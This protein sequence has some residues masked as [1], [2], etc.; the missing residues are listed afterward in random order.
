MDFEEYRKKHHKPNMSLM[1]LLER[2][3]R[4]KKLLEENNVPTTSTGNISTHEPRQNG[5]RLR[6]TETTPQTD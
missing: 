2:F 3:H 6:N 4:E 5:R 1:D